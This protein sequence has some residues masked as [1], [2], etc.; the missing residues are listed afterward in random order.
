[1]PALHRRLLWLAFALACV[2]VAASATLRLAANGIGCTPW[3]AC[4]GLVETASA[5]QQT[6]L[7]QTLRLTH[8]IAASSFALV[9]LGAVLIGWTRWLRTARAM[10]VALLLV[11]AVL[12]G[13]GRYTPSPLPLI[14]LINV[15]GGFSLLVLLA[16]LLAATRDAATPGATPRFVA[17]ACSLLL[18]ILA[19]QAAS[20]ALISARLAGDACATAGCGQ[21]WLPGASVLL[22]PLGAGSARQLLSDP[23][24]GQ[25]LHMLHRALGLALLLLAWSV[26]K[27]WPR[28]QAQALRLAA[29]ALTAALLTGVVAATL[30]GSLAAT[31]SHVLLAGL[32]AAGLGVALAAGNSRLK[33]V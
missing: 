8:R 2:V 14:T 23:A 20:G 1:M 28:Q 27:S 13:I 25:A 15:L 30:D 29:W 19:W 3:P 6:T 24:A 22:N 7:V 4:Y 9:A 32:A 33:T 31:V 18:L 26:V 10:G 16:W 21:F 17:V 11:T 5:A 12:A